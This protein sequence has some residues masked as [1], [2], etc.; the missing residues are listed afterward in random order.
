VD[1]VPGSRAA[2]FRVTALETAPD[3][4][5]WARAVRVST[6]SPSAS[7]SPITYARARSWAGV[8]TGRGALATAITWRHARSTENAVS[9]RSP[10]GTRGGPISAA[11]APPTA[12]RPATRRA[13]HPAAQPAEVRD[14]L[15]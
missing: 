2:T 15:A 5:A 6:S 1:P 14:R 13:P 11:V 7:S 10:A 3:Q 8:P 9:G 4:R 12:R